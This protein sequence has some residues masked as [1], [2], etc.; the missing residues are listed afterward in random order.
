MYR[1][2]IIINKIFYIKDT[3]IYFLFFA[4]YTFDAHTACVVVSYFN[5]YSISAAIC[6]TVILNKT[7]KVSFKL[8]NSWRQRKYYYFFFTDIYTFYAS[9]ELLCID[10]FIDELLQVD[11]FFFLIV[12]NHDFRFTFNIHIYIYLGA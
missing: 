10:T 4:S 5:G 6:L 12:Y 7:L 8:S 2:I 11:V 9:R 1:I 3:I